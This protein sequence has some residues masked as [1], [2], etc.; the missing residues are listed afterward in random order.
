M[1][2][3]SSTWIRTA[4][5]AQRGS[6]ALLA[7]GGAGLCSANDQPKW[8]PATASPWLG[9]RRA[10]RR[11]RVRIHTTP[12][13]FGAQR[14]LLSERSGKGRGSSSR[15]R[16]FM[17]SYEAAGFSRRA[18]RLGGIV[19]ERAAQAD[20]V[21]SLDISTRRWC[22]ASAHRR[23][24]PRRARP[25]PRSGAG[26]PART[27]SHAASN[28]HRRQE[29]C[30]ACSAGEGRLYRRPRRQQSRQ[31][32]A[33]RD[34]LR[35]PT[36]G[37]GRDAAGLDGAFQRPLVTTRPSPRRG[38]SGPTSMPSDRDVDKQV[39]LIGTGRPTARGRSL[40]SDGNGWQA[41]RPR[42]PSTRP[43]WPALSWSVA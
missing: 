40:R 4:R 23:G 37:D 35:P 10:R 13:Q 32:L 29:S 1:L 22:T 38:N 19:R 11:T 33:A 8:P 25:S 42:Q 34:G 16:E 31:Q 39:G 21:L 36:V 2:S 3:A 6:G 15:R 18:M 28:R 30:P 27:L 43:G 41:S 7:T 17:T 26:R 12:L 24:G 9:G 20:G 5:A 14:F